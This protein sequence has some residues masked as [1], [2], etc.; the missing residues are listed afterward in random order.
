MPGIIIDKKS[1]QYKLGG[2]APTTESRLTEG[3][4]VEKRGKMN[5]PAGSNSPFSTEDSDEE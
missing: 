1:K 2:P 5:K 4:K 3:Q